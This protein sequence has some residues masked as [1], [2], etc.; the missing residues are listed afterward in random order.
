M[1]PRDALLIR[2]EADRR[3]GTG[4]VMRC[5]ALAQ[6]WTNAGGSARFALA[7]T[8]DSVADRIA[9]EGLE[10]VHLESP[11]SLADDADQTISALSSEH[12]G[13]LAVDGYGFDAAYQERVTSAGV[14]LLFVDDY[15]HAGRY[16]A[17]LV[18]NQNL[19]ATEALYQ[20]RETR[21]RLLLGTR[22]ALLRREFVASPPGDRHVPNEA[23]RVLVTLGG[24]D[25]DNVTGIVLRALRL[26]PELELDIVVVAG[27]A[28]AHVDL[29]RHD[30]EAFPH[31]VRLLTNV[32]DMPQL[33]RWADLAV[34]AGGSTCWELA[35]MGVPIIAIV[36][37]PNQE[38]I[39]RSLAQS[40]AARDA[41]QGRNLSA[42]RLA[43]MIRELVAS[44]PERRRMSER[45]RALVDGCGA[46]RVVDAM[47]SLQ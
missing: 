24:S 37:A 31:A 28:N 44:A 2:T 3:T 18:L 5:L 15:G 13:W 14:P 10:V 20:H 4:H 23:R 27:A 6:A 39:A 12:G 25:P 41:G 42:V 47:R 30:I 38:P 40:G 43:E 21:T 9:Q 16:S 11:A 8:P 32:S 7:N 26:A 34:S 22:Y 17:D 33:M 46:Q 1:S 19:Y 35:Y 45:G 36:L 29:L